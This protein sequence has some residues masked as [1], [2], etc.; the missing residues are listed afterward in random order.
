MPDKSCVAA[1][2]ERARC[3]AYMNTLCVTAEA[4]GTVKKVAQGIGAAS[5]THSPSI[6]ADDP[7]PK[8]RSRRANMDTRP[9]D[10]A[11][12][13]RACA[14]SHHHLANRAPSRHPG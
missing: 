10:V 9:R 8:I 14:R 2:F 5:F 6:T 3:H 13:H 4:R 1:F 11:R 12:S 7:S